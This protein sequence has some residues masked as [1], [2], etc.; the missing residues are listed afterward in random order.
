MQ[1]KTWKIKKMSEKLKNGGKWPRRQLYTA[2]QR[3]GGTASRRAAQVANVPL[4][5]G[6]VGLP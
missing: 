1:G 4:E 2:E 3:S 5:I 6:V